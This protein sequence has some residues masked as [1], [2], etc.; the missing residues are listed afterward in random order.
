MQLSRFVTA[1]KTCP[2]YNIK[3]CI[4]EPCKSARVAMSYD[5][6]CANFVFTLGKVPVKGQ[7]HI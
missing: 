1:T 6:I 4:S 5:A 3:S 2:S 7:T